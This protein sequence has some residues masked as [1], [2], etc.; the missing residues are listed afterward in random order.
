MNLVY[1]ASAGTGKTSQVAQH[2]IDLMINQ[3]L[4]PRRILLMTF[5]DNAAAEL[6]RRITQ[7]LSLILSEAERNNEDT[8]AERCRQALS[9]L[10]VAAISTMHAYCTALLREHAIEAG[11]SPGFSILANDH[12]RRLLKEISQNELLSQL[13]ADPD[14]CRFCAG[15]PLSVDGGFGASVP[16]TAIALIQQ[17]G[18]LG[19]DLENAANLLEPPEL[20]PSLATFKALLE[21]F[22]QLPKL[23]PALRNAKESI[24]NAL[25]T[26][27]TVEELLEQL[28]KNKFSKFGK[29]NK[30]LS[31]KIFDA[32]ERAESAIRYRE[33]FPAVLAFAR[34][35]QRVAATFRREKKMLDVVDFNDMQQLAIRLI[36]REAAR[37]CF[38]Y[39]I[40]DE[41]QDTSRIQCH[42]IQALWK[43]SK[44]LI[45][46]GD[47][48][49]SI[50]T[51]RG[52]DPAVMPDLEQAILE[53]GGSIENLQVSYRSKVPLLEPINMLFNTLYPDYSNGHELQPNP[54]FETPEEKP[55]VEFMAYDG[56]ESEQTKNERID[57]EMQAVARRI[58]LLV[59]GNEE[60]RPNYRYTGGFKAVNAQNTYRYS[61]ILI[62]LRVSTHQ[63]VL[64]Q[65][66]RQSGIPYTLAGKG[67]GLFSTPEARD[68][69]LLLE[70]L[71]NPANMQ[72]LI[73]FLRSPWI[74]LSDETLA[75][76]VW[77]TPPE[78]AEA[79]LRHFPAVEALVLRYRALL[80]ARLSSEVVRL[81][82]EETGY[83]AL[84]AAQPHGEQCLANLRKIIDW[85]RQHEYGAKTTPAAIN[86]TLQE[87]VLAPPKIAE[88]VQQSPTQNAAVIMSVHGAK[89][90]TKRVVFVP[91]L[92]F[93]QTP[94]R[95]FAFLHV[96]G[97]STRLC[98]RTTA[99]DRSP[100]SS[101]GFS[102]ARES[103]K[104]IREVELINLLYVAMTRA[105]DLLVMSS[106]ELEKPKGWLKV[107]KPFLGD[108]IVSRPFGEVASATA[109][110]SSAVSPP[111]TLR[112]EHFTAALAT[113]PERS[114][115]PA[116]R[117]MSA[118]TLTAE[119][120]QLEDDPLYP[121]AAL[122]SNKDCTLGSLGH[123][124]LDQLAFHEWQGSASV[125]LKRLHGTFQLSEADALQ[126]TDKIEAVCQLML[127]STAGAES[128]FPSSRF[129]LMKQK[130]LIDG[131]I[132]LLATYPE[133]FMV[134]DYKF[135][136]APPEHLAGCYREQ[137]SIYRQAAIKRF[138]KSQM[139]RT[140]LIAIP[141]GT[142][143][144]LDIRF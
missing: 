14:F 117:R 44:Y 111:A 1:N 139:Q 140:S 101:P 126:L 2:C 31:N 59:K 91:G 76:S 11:Y 15:K 6:R 12:H 53:K 52:A 26:S 107:V 72:A 37:P 60:W 70:V 133:G 55:C 3:Q 66:L 25:S 82:V 88:A 81:I 79:F 141:D 127:E 112:A 36:E 73:G 84:L 142:P 65:A 42:L 43:T 49:Q 90:L 131:V 135:S 38:E 109:G 129:V 137:L 134:F 58:Q 19:I 124:V 29:S 122:E 28:R 9:N 45:I 106:S 102:S 110:H 98:V 56:T 5:T 64:E 16:E 21:R 94:D 54:A 35:L 20:P 108:Q 50:Y 119:K 87:H 120:D 8:T 68:T 114:V 103:V 71:N 41:V 34:Y 130:T 46:C 10:P 99:P 23:T 67:H 27:D 7:K 125:W 17:A 77:D 136:N 32:L 24:A 78:N 143:Y 95:S 39:V 51:W 13:R 128:L 63:A 105:R 62:L 104:S 4:D 96:D 69:A 121:H 123:A 113:L 115:A 30:Q 74:G 80:A 40:I 75:T 18:S 47:K 48:K 118:T 97:S 57:A 138:P 144:R 93:T 83:H 92:S 116:F 85:L 61:D 100:V 22:N 86:R 89:G 132:D 33:G